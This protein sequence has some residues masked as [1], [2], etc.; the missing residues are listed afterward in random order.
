MFGFSCARGVNVE[1]MVSNHEDE[2]SKPFHLDGAKLICNTVCAGVAAGENRL[3]WGNRNMV[4]NCVS[5]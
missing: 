2:S 3:V 4:R 5:M 1:L